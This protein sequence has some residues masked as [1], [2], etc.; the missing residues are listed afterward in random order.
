MIMAARGWYERIFDEKDGE[1][2]DTV[3]IEIEADTEEER[4]E[5]LHDLSVAHEVLEEC[6]IFKKHSS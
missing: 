1:I 6:G 3:K 4:L 5:C 2:Q